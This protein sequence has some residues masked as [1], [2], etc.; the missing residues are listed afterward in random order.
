MR[1]SPCA[2]GPAP[3]STSC[4]RSSGRRW[5]SPPVHGKTAE[6]RIGLISPPWIP[7]PPAA[8][9]GT[10]LVVALLARGLAEA[11]HEVLLAAA[12][13]S[14]CP[15]PLVPGLAA[16]DPRAVGSTDTELTHVIR[17]YAAMDGM[18]LVHDHTLAGPLYRHRPPAVP[19]VVT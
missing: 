18:D 10:E 5:K 9:G 6:M 12:S 2:A 19:L 4:S 8:D 3:R 16:A 1:R 13:D 17:A 11:G 14:A 7:L 15:V